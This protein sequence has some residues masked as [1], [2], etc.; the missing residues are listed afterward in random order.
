MN[1]TKTSKTL[2]AAAVMA[3][4]LCSATA[5]FAGTQNSASATGTTNTRIITPISL[6]YVS[7]LNFGDVVSSSS[8]GTVVVTTAAARSSTGGTTL[9]NSTGVA[10]AAFTV[11]G[12]GSSTYAITLPSTSSIASGANSMTV[13]AYTSNPSTTG[14]LSAGGS[15]GLAVGATLNVGASQPTGSYTGTFNVTVAYN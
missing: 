12:Q 1:A 4:T 9:G 11:G 3:G 7:N 13:D 10:A 2:L 14:T 8:A 5:A 6:T 15:Q